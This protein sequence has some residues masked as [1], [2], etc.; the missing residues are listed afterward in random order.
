[1]LP[2]H[3]QLVAQVLGEPATAAADR[4]HRVVVDLAPGHD[5][6]PL[7]EELAEGTHQ[8]GLALPALAEQHQV[9]P[10]QQRALQLRE[11][12]VVEAD[13]PREG[14]VPR[15]QPLEEVLADL[16]LDRP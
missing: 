11:H 12:G 14:G 4:S 9:V 3:R 1:V 5:R 7:V 10:G 16:G 15:A 2:R 8:A 6:R 13:D